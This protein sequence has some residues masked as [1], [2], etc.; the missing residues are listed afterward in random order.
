VVTAPAVR[1]A[2]SVAKKFW[3]MPQGS[4]PYVAVRLV[5]SGSLGLGGDH[6]M[7]QTLRS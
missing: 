5:R 7:R 6:G 2:A 3:S 1:L 4:R